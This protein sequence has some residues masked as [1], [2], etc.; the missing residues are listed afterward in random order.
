MAVVDSAAWYRKYRPST[1]ADYIGDDIKH[2]VKA[3]FTKPENRPS[4]IMISGDRGC[5]KTTF[6]RIVS[7]YYLCENPVD[8]EPCEKCATCNNINDVL[9]AGETG[10]DIDGIVEIDATTANGKDEIQSIIEDAIQPP[11]YTK[12]KVLILDECHMITP[13]A[14]NSL[15]KVI[16][17]IPPHLV[18]IFCTT[19]IEKVLGTILSRCQLKLE[20]HKKTVDEM[21][22]RLLYIAQQEGLTTSKEAL[23][24][25]AK[26][27][28]RVPRESIN[29]LESIAKNY[30]N[31]VTIENVRASTGEV[32]SDIYM[33]YYKAANTGLEDILI[34]NQKL[35]ESSIE[36]KSFISGLTRFTLDCLYIRHGIALDDYPIEYLEQ[37]KDL[38]EMYKSSEFDALLQVIEAASKSIG[39]DDNKSELIITT[40]AMRIGKIG[41]IAQGL[42]KESAE[43]DKEN[44]ESIANYRESAKKDIADQINH[45]RSMAT[46]KESI[47]DI[48]KDM[49][50]VKGTEGCRILAVAESE[51]EKTSGEFMSANELNK[52]LES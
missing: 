49:H 47:A 13:Q 44:R 25:I 29:M 48:L 7:K 36:A 4:V 34:F 50:D 19:N 14:Q 18:V 32:A 1:M 23:K 26:K 35:K 37:V 12:K 40:T 15:L 24:I 43:A 33:Q 2:V 39:Y 30:G 8:G 22:D 38:F 21:A 17:D 11:L 51:Q 41:L 42:D 52:L 20:V 5:G 27:T 10:V 16:E 3:R 31:K 45:T 46:T 6:A 28:D 9:I